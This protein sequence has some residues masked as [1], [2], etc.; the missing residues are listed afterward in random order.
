MGLR[1]VHILGGGLGQRREGKHSSA[2]L[3]SSRVFMF[4]AHRTSLMKAV[5]HFDSL[6]WT[7][8]SGSTLCICAVV[9]FMPCAPLIREGSQ[10]KM[11]LGVHSAVNHATEVTHIA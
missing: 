1:N 8:T 2:S 6:Y 11:G 5:D 10:S 4:R 3:Y 9:A 7:Q